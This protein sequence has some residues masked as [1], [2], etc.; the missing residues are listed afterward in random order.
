MS[1]Q[2]LIDLLDSVSLEL[3]REAELVVAPTSPSALRS[4]A[5]TRRRRR[6]LF[7]LVVLLVLI[8]SVVLVITQGA[9]HQSSP[10][11]AATSSP[12]PVE[13][14]PTRSP[15]AAESSTVRPVVSTGDVLTMLGMGDLTLGMPRTALVAR[16]VMAPVGG[17]DVT[18]PA[19]S[20]ASEGILISSGTETVDFIVVHTPQHSTQSGVRVG[21]TMGQVKQ[22]YGDKVTVRTVTLEIGDP[23]GN[24]RQA[25]VIASGNTVIFMSESRG[26]IAA[27]DVVTSITLLRGSSLSVPVEIC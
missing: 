16:G 23:Q 21:M 4:A 17:C 20:L 10:T 8:L 22:I 19:P 3:D 2:Q 9:A 15:S 14:A 18:N 12:P 5:S 24:T 26:P 27:S 13:T 11:W 6:L 25:Y 1:D 7:G